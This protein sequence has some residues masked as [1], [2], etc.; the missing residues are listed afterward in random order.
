MKRLFRVFNNTLVGDLIKVLWSRLREDRILDALAL[1]L[2]AFA[3]SLTILKAISIEPSG[4]GQRL[5]SYWCQ[6]REAHKDGCLQLFYS[7]HTTL[8]QALSFSLFITVIAL[9]AISMK[10][11]Y[12]AAIIAVFALVFLG[13]VPP[14]ELIAGVEWKLILFLIGSMIFAYVLRSLGVFRLIALTIM[15]TSRGSPTIFLTM[16]L[17]ISWFL[18]L[19]VDEATSIIYV[20][21]LLLDFK[22]LTG[23]DITPFIVLA[24]LATNTG[25]MAM[26][27][28]NPIGIYLAFTAGLHAEDFARVALPL[29]LVTLLLLVVVSRLLLGQRIRELIESIKPEKVEVVFTE[30]YTRVD[31]RGRVHIFYG[32]ALLVMFLL[33]VSFSSVLASGLSSIYGHL[34]EP[35][36]FLS[37]IPY[38]FIFLSLW[39]YEPEKLEVALLKGVEWPSLFFFI[40]L[41][42]LGHSLLWTGVAM[43]IAYL[44]SILSSHLGGLAMSEIL[45]V[46]TASTSAFLDNL[47]VIVAFTP[48]ADGL[49]AMG[50]SRSVYW[51]LLYGGTLGGNFTPIG[52]TA[53]I[54]AIGLC[55]KA[56]VRV[57]WSSWFRVAFIPT[58]LQLLAAC[59]WATFLR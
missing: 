27:I 26:P 54:V 52:S 12:F 9:T 30:F 1:L 11:R 51:V 25:S 33:T 45:L 32:L 40:A 55:E 29:S 44:I 10:L 15:R 6:L 48:V 16:L 13:V 7:Q 50:I 58:I 3:A 28:G 43:K 39:V 22:K 38:V 46:T 14:Q 18:A 21:A 35:H 19:A 34:I 49:V 8:E 47:S 36:A 2:I 4:V 17:T 31:R 41:F 57:T 23:R 56:K 37:F 24:V 42:M 59:A 5:I 20:I 53:N